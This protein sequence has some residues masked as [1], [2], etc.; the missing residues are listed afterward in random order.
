[1]YKNVGS[2]KKCK[3]NCNMKQNVFSVVAVVTHI[4]DYT[5]GEDYT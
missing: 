4:Q 3:M 1:M 5:R 2:G